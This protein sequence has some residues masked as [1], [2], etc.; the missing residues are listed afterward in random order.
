[1][2]NACLILLLMSV[3]VGAEASKGKL[4]TYLL[5]GQSNMAGW[6]DYSSLDPAWAKS[7]EQNERIHFC[8]S[9]TK[10]EVAGLTASRGA[11][12]QPVDFPKYDGVHYNTDGVLNIGKAL[13][14]KVCESRI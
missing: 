10:W 7:L 14:R 8:S 13:A 2:K 1:M 11:V 5:M 9:A 3:A 4:K 12:E 6:G